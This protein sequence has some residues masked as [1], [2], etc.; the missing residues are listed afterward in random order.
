MQKALI[1]VDRA[2]KTITNLP[3]GS[4]KPETKVIVPY[5]QIGLV[6]LSGDVPRKRTK[7]NCKGY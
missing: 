1:D 2:I 7:S 3:E 4:E 6:L 5:E